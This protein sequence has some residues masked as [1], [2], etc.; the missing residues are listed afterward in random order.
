MALGQC[1]NS[2]RALKLKP[3]VAADTAG[4]AREI[5]EANDPTRAAIASRLAAE[6]YG[7]NILKENVEDESNST[8]RFVVLSREKKWAEPR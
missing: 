5:A 2:M 6:I 1:R 8:T 7:L 4:S 3:I